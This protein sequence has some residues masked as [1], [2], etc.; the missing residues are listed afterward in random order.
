[1]NVRSDLFVFFGTLIMGIV[2]FLIYVA[3]FRTECRND[4]HFLEHLSS[5]FEKIEGQ[6]SYVIVDRDGGVL[7]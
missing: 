5:R 1:M 6:T 2:G 3:V 4:E 7:Q